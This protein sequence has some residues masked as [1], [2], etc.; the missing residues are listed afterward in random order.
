MCSLSTVIYSTEIT[1]KKFKF[2]LKNFCK[3]FVRV[4]KT[5]NFPYLGGCFFSGNGQNPYSQKNMPLKYILDQ[6]LEGG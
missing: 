1:F 5:R 2:L 6:L 4:K 3:V